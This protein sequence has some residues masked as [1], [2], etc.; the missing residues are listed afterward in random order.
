MPVDCAIS[1]C[2]SKNK[3]TAHYSK[4]WGGIR[5]YCND[6]WRLASIFF[7]TIVDLCKNCRV[8]YLAEY[9]EKARRPATV[10]ILGRFYNMCP[11]HLSTY[12]RNLDYFNPT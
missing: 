2:N 6:C 9:E 5:Y 1:D 11:K 7:G 4:D 10:K 12:E 3:N 8:N